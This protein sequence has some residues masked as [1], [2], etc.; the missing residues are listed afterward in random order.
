MKIPN[1]KTHQRTFQQIPQ[2]RFYPYVGVNYD[3]AKVKILVLAH[4]R[5]CYPL[6]WEDVKRNTAYLNYF[7][8]SVGEFAFT[9][10]WYTK[11]F[12]NFLKGAL[13]IKNNFYYNSV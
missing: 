13:G 8:Y 7:S 10:A 1:S 12:R 4:N 2:I 3:S 9:K 6:D 5:Y 11:S